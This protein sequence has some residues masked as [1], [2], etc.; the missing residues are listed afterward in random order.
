MSE[1]EPKVGAGATGGACPVISFL[2]L[3]SCLRLHRIV[4]AVLASTAI[5]LTFGCGGGG[6]DELAF[7]SDRDGDPEIYVMNADGS[8]QTPLTNNGALDGEPRWSPD[9][10]WIAFISEES[11][12]REINRVE[13]GKKDATP[14]R[15]THSDGMDETHRWSPNGGRLAFVS[16]RDGQPEIYLMDGNGSNFTRVTSDPSQPRL[17]GW[18]PDG[19]WIAFTLEGAGGSSGII[20]RNP[21]GVNV[22]PLTDAEDYGA[23]W[24][25]DGKKIAFI[26]VRDGNEEI[27]M[28]NPDGSAQTR[29]TH[30]TSRDSQISWS[31]DGQWIAFVSER[32]GEAE[33]YV[34]KAD[35]AAQIRHTVNKAKDET[36]VWS[37]DGKRI[38]FAS[39]M[40]GTAEIIIMDAD[41][42]N[43]HRLTN[44][45]ANDTQPAW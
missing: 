2:S 1:S 37:P 44:N 24:S 6:T 23:V 41:G 15:L 40:Y 18:S 22:Q 3:R 5:L 42:S 36:P 30:N 39:Y 38:A 25:P 17:S 33:I 19:Q 43:Q 31:P 29:L 45:S 11:G 13:V 4:V 12:D 8:G 32:D 16:N 14:E 21:D 10:K 34:M 7:V 35:G 20:T 28:M 27:Y 9:R 26:S